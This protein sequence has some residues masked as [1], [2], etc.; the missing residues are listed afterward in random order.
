MGCNR[1]S[2]TRR[3]R[4]STDVEIQ[5]QSGNAHH[6]NIGQGFGPLSHIFI[7]HGASVECP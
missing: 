7:S 4:K 2:R 5:C 3:D 6:G 1:K